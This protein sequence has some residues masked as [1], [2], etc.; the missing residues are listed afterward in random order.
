MLRIRNF[1]TLLSS[2]AP[3]SKGESDVI[4]PAAAAVV[5]PAAVAAVQPAQAIAAP[6]DS[7]QASGYNDWQLTE[8]EWASISA[9]LDADF[10]R[11]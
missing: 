4:Q 7:A 5:Q 10:Q 9:K 3:A 8:Q 11:Y 2:V 1:S 6:S